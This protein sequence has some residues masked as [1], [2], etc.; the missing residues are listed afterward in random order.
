MSKIDDISIF[1]YGASGVSLE[2]TDSS[3]NAVG[4]DS[5][6]AV[7]FTWTVSLWKLRSSDVVSKQIQFAAVSINNEASFTTT[8][9]TPHGPLIEGTFSLLLDGVPVRIYD[10]STGGY[11][12]ANIP[13]DVGQ[14]TLANA[15]KNILGTSYVSVRRTGTCSYGCKW[16]VTFDKLDL[17]VPDF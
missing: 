7:T 3:G 17:D 15:F 14:G 5:V 2:I 1:N 16:V 6:N 4:G 12:N 10:S 13:Y 11:D 9:V 8:I